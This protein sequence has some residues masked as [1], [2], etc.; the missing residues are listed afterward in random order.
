MCEGRQE[1]GREGISRKFSKRER[2]RELESSEL[3]YCSGGSACG[4]FPLCSSAPKPQLATLFFFFCEHVWTTAV[5]VAVTVAVAASF[6]QP[7]I[8]LPSRQRLIM[9]FSQKISIRYELSHN[10]ECKPWHVE[11]HVREPLG[12]FLGV[13]ALS[14]RVRVRV[15]ASA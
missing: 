15:S 1:K 11:V 10:W 14:L 3:S 2:E 12:L 8:V 6:E 9:K 4:W 7:P 5:A 13:V